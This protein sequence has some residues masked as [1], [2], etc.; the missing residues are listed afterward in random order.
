VLVNTLFKSPDF[1]NWIPHHQ[2]MSQSLWT[3]LDGYLSQPKT[4]K[5]KSFAPA[6]NKKRSAGV[7]TPTTDLN[8][9]EL[10]GRK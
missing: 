4:K 1:K 5:E 3:V 7:T 9:E 6:G 2:T 10:L 8:W